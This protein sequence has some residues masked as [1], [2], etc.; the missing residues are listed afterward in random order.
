MKS[1]LPKLYNTIMTKKRKK[2][3]IK[4]FICH[5]E[6][7]DEGL[8]SHLRIHHND[9]SERIWDFDFNDMTSSK[10]PYASIFV[11]R[12][13]KCKMCGKSARNGI[14]QHYMQEHSNVVSFLHKWNVKIK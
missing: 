4:C 11:R 14:V 12:K 1:M 13:K 7:G 3:E 10:P 9:L 2:S 5:I 6:C 8:H